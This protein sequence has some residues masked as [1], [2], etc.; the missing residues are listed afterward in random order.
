M[1]EKH[2]SELELLS[3]V[4]EEL[5]GE[6][7]RDVAEHL[8]A[9]RTCADEIRRLEAARDA[10]RSAPL[11]ELPDE[12]R[13]EILAS[14]P[15][16]R[17]RWR[18]FRPAR[19]AL[20]IAAPVAAAAALVAV[21]VVGGTQLRS[22][23]DDEQGEAADVAA[24]ESAGGGATAPRETEA[25][26]TAT[27]EAAVPAGPPGTTFVLLTQGPP[28]AIVRALQDEGIEA[29]VDPGGG[30]VAAAQAAD[31]RAALAGRPDGSV[32]VYVR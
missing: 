5:D 3:F 32:P 9:C 13:D 11:L 12:R 24:E 1:A 25:A 6:A 21:L 2:P 23:G 27:G 19:R 30:V 20:V 26:P 18:R 10:L 22:S 29:R 17:D 16:R 14:L 28:A 4:E 31:V 7:R 15:E 8:V